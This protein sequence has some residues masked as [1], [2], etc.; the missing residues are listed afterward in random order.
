MI[1]MVRCESCNARIMERHCY[2][3]T[4]E[5]SKTKEIVELRVCEKCKETFR[6]KG[7]HLRVVK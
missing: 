5:L 2:V 7:H 6:T 4:V 1:N 3:V